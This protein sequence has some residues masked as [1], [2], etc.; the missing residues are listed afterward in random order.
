M[1]PRTSQ[2]RLSQQSQ[3]HKSHEKIP[4]TKP[5]L[6]S[7]TVLGER[8]QTPIRKAI[9]STTSQGAKAS[10][11]ASAQVQGSRCVRCENGA[12]T[13]SHNARMAA[14]SSQRSLG[15][16]TTARPLVAALQVRVG[17]R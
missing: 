10:R 8:I 4:T 9:S 1:A 6:G 16:R 14:I 17:P 11:R 15:R 13:A 7:G 3:C 2:S 12:A 5:V